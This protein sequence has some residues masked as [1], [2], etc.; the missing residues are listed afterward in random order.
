MSVS[1]LPAISSA[2]LTF[3]SKNICIKSG[4]RRVLRAG[5][6]SGC[7]KMQK[8]GIFHK[9]CLDHHRQLKSR[10][11][12]AL[13]FFVFLNAIFMLESCYADDGSG[14]PRNSDFRPLN[15]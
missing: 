9:K 14:C 8:A 13:I 2:K 12:L 6:P 4:N 10:L 1:K 5:N 15:A 11:E 7:W 3:A